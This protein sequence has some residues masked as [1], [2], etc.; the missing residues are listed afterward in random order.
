MSRKVFTGFL[1]ALIVGLSTTTILERAHALRPDD[2][3]VNRL[4]AQLNHGSHR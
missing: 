1:A 4:L 3:A 2:E